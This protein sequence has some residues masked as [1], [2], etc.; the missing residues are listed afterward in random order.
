LRAL[1]TGLESPADYV[2]FLEDDLDFNHHLRHNLES[3]RPVRD[4][5]FSLA[6]LYNPQL[7]EVGFDLAS[8]TRL[9]APKSVYGSQAFLLSKA[10]LRNVIRRWNRVAGFGDL[11]IARLAGDP[12][13]PI[14]YH[15]PSL[16]Q[17]VG[18]KSVW[19]GHFHQAADFDPEWKA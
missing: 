14:F 8:N 4:R 19:G 12:G 7:S 6:S 10:G 11:R 13:E 5:R 2:L 3:W 16:V 1:H 9:M 17:H 18:R 15:A